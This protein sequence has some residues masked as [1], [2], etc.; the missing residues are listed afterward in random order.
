M[1][2][3]DLI[4]VLENMDPDLLVII[5]R[6]PEGNGYAPMGDYS[7]G[8]F[9]SKNDEF[10]EDDIDEDWSEDEDDESITIGKSCV[11]LWPGY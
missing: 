9:D 6:D 5:A 3:K 1:L 8:V 7:V 2:V 11:V 4:E 10:A